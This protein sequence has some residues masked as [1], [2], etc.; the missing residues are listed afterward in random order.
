MYG[1]FF[2]ASSDAFAQLMIENRCDDSGY[3]ACHCAAVYETL[4]FKYCRADSQVKKH[5][6]RVLSMLQLQRREIA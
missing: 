2:V 3:L 6:T 1:L 5:L 4:T